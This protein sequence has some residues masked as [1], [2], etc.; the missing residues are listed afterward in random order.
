MQARLCLCGLWCCSVAGADGFILVGAVGLLSLPLGASVS[1][2]TKLQLL[3]GYAHETSRNVLFT[4][5]FN[6]P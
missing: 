4:K 3:Q 2:D 1:T 6:V 5:A